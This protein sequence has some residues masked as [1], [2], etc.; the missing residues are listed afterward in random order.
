MKNN[1]NP[2]VI[3]Y[4]LG[5]GGLSYVG[6]GKGIGAVGLN[7][8]IAHN[9][10]PNISSFYNNDWFSTRLIMF[11]F[12]RLL[13]FYWIISKLFHNIPLSYSMFL[14]Q[15]AWICLYKGESKCIASFFPSIY[16]PEG[17]WRCGSERC[18]VKANCFMINGGQPD[19]VKEIWSWIKTYDY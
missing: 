8:I 17:S 7:W 12:L 13:V 19:G 2:F 11:L 18:V 1:T 3:Q 10:I 9:I 15:L 6:R 4:W 5:R 14:T 16:V